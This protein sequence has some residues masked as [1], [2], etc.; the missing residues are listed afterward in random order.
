M[1][2]DPSRPQ[3]REPL[4]HRRPIQP[5]WIE[6][7]GIPVG[8]AVLVLLGLAALFVLFPSWF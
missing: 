7:Y 6:E 1:S 4:S 2:P 3:P 8:G 5:D